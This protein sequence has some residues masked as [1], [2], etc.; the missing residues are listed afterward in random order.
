MEGQPKIS[1]NF[2]FEWR[3]DGEEIGTPGENEVVND[4]EDTEELLLPL[5]MPELEIT[6]VIIE[7]LENKIAKAD[8]V[9][10]LLLYKAA[11][12]LKRLSCILIFFL[13]F[14]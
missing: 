12:K 11:C 14:P 7:R 8:L 4:E 1:S 13:Q 5:D 6:D 10:H 2:K 3:I 9:K